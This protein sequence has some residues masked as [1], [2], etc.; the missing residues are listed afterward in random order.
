MLCVSDKW[1]LHDIQINLP[2]VTG[3]TFLAKL[4]LRMDNNDDDDDDDDEDDDNGYNCT[5]WNVF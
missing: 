4:R 2:Q 3:T 5:P 1:R